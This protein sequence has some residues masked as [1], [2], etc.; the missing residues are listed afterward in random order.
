MTNSFTL[1]R[2]VTFYH[3]IV[4]IKFQ[5]EAERA[6]CTSNWERKKKKEKKPKWKMTCEITMSVI[7]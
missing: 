4:M 7:I 3:Q 2:S 1:V 5:G 6:D